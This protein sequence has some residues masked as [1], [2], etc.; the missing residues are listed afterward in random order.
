MPDCV[1]IDMIAP[2]VAV[3]NLAYYVCRNT[4][5]SSTGKVHFSL[6]ASLAGA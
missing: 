3:N 1:R 5:N 4:S 6:G 2:L